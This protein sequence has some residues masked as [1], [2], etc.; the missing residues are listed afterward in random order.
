[1]ELNQIQGA[2]LNL[3]YLR[4]MSEKQPTINFNGLAKHYQNDN[5]KSL[6]VLSHEFLY[7]C[8]HPKDDDL[9][10]CLERN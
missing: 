6:T 4:L 7:S 8:F 5:V 2:Y 3:K 10:I 1:M 9:V